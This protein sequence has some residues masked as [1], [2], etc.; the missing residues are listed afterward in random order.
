MFVQAGERLS[1]RSGRPYL[2]PMTVYLAIPPD[3]LRACLG[4]VR[5]FV[6]LAL[7]GITASPT[8]PP[9]R[10]AL[11]LDE[12]GR[13]DRLADSVTLLRGYGARLWLSVQDVFQPKAVYP[14]WQSFRRS[15]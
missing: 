4:F 1:T 2:L 14:R 6:S 13:M 3:R 8:R 11:F 5:G 12:L 15:L 7:D 9:H 10:I